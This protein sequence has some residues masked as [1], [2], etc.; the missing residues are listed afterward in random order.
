MV[1]AVM[2]TVHNEHKNKLVMID[3]DHRWPLF[4][5]GDRKVDGPGGKE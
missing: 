2:A 3:D 1:V 4:I 5:S